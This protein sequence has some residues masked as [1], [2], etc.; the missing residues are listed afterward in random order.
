VDL[1][2]AR[3]NAAL[4]YSSTGAPDAEHTLVVAHSLATSRAWEDETGLFDWTAV[5]ASGHRVTRFDTR[6][7][8]ESTGV[9]GAEH[10]TWPSLAEDYVAVADASS[11][12]RPVDGIGQS[13]GCGVLLW[14][15]VT[16]PE[17]FRRLVLVIP[18]TRGEERQ[19]QAQLYL[20]AA[21][22][23]ELRGTEAWQRVVSVAAPAPILKAGGWPR[24]TWIAVREGLVPSVLRGAAGS[25]L[26]DD[27]QLRGLGHR[28]LLLTWDDDPSHPVASA[29]YLAE[30]IPGSTL[31]VAHG[32]DEVRGWGRR[33]AAFLDAD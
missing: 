19:A 23:I 2:L 10:Y 33:V 17:R 7:H 26:P 3:P 12:D 30:R 31:E 1:H 11:P 15:A 21:E 22:M 28:T 27:E 5:T 32:P 25:V 14:A 6:G 18:P 24:P 13:T 4:A 16:R 9:A 8:G 29:R 20:A